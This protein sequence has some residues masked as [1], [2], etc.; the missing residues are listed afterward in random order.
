[1]RHK[2]RGKKLNRNSSHRKAMLRNMAVSLILLARP[3]DDAGGAGHGRLITTVSK[4]KFL[5]PFVDRLVTLSKRAALAISKAPEVPK[6]GSVSWN[7][8]RASQGWQDWVN[9]VSPAVTL[10][11]RAFA[12]LRSD[13]AVSVLFDDLARRF[14]SRNGG[15]VRVVRIAARR[16]GD[17]GQQALIEFVGERD[18]RLGNLKT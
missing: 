5:R 17:S 15:Y 11:R 10:R 13:V 9:I 1:M 8:W 3:T 18:R 4:A 12:M 7:E 14:E 2:R 16:V 6:R